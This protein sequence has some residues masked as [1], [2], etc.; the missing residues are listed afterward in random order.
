MSKL[1]LIHTTFTTSEKEFW[2]S[3][4]NQLHTKTHSQIK[5]KETGDSQENTKPFTS[6]LILNTEDRKAET[7]TFRFH[8]LRLFIYSLFS[9]LSLWKTK[10]YLFQSTFSSLKREQEPYEEGRTHCCP[11]HISIT[12]LGQATEGSW[13]TP[14]RSP[15]RASATTILK[16]YFG[17]SMILWQGK[18]KHIPQESENKIQVI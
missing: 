13:V 9:E 4:Y 18:M 11:L 10:K 14:A 5:A 17:T 6:T 7:W 16:I 1:I 8:M 15:C 2:V 12:L 3:I